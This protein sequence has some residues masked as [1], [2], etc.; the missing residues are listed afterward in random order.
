MKLESFENKTQDVDTGID[1][2]NKLDSLDKPLKFEV[3]RFDDTNDNKRDTLESL[4][5]PL[6]CETDKNMEIPEK[7][8]YYTTYD[9][10]LEHTPQE[11]CSYGKWE[12][13]RGESKFIPEKESAKE[14]LEKYGQDGIVYQDAI[15]DFSECSEANVEIDMTEHRQSTIDQNTKERIV[16]NFEKADAECAKQWNEIG[17]DGKND[18]T[19]RDISEWRGK[20]QYT[21]HECNDMR[22]CNLVPRAIHEECKHSGGVAECKRRDAVNTGGGFDE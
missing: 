5:K 16:G 8:E 17:K 9:E 11:D 15:P 20:N 22:T 1:N 2:K 14:A 10:R 21:W 3:D 13:S 12:G 6:H 7:K 19:A 18:W 4:D